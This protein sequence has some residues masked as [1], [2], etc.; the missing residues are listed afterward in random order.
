MASYYYTQKYRVLKRKEASFSSDNECDSFSLSDTTHDNIEDMFKQKRLKLECTSSNNESNDTSSLYL[1]HYDASKRDVQYV[2][3]INNDVGCNNLK[4]C[5]YSSFNEC[6]NSFLA[7]STPEPV[8]EAE[9]GKT[10]KKIPFREK[11]KNLCLDNINNITNKFVSQLLILLR[12]EGLDVPTC[13]ETLLGTNKKLF[14]YSIKSMLSSNG[15]N[16]QYR[17]FGIFTGISQQI[18]SI[19]YTDD[20][21]QIIV[22]ID[23]FDLYQKSSQKCWPI[24]IQLYHLEHQFQPFIAALYC[25]PGKPA[26]VHDF[27]H[28][29]VEEA[30]N[31]I[32]NGLQIKDKKFAFQLKAIICDTP[33]R[34][35]IK[36]C[37][38]HIGFFSCKRCETKGLSIAQKIG[39]RGTKK[40]NQGSKKRIFPQTDARRRTH[41]SFKTQRQN[42]HHLKGII[43]PLLKIPGFDVI[44]GVLLDYMH[45]LCIGVTKTLLHY[46]LQG[47]KVC[48]ISLRNRLLLKEM[49]ESVSNDVPSEFQRKKFDLDDIANWKATQF[50]FFL[51]YCGSF[52]RYVLSENAYK[53]YLLLFA[54][55]RIL[56]S[57]ECV[58]KETYVTY[59]NDLLI[60]FFI[61]LPTF[62]GKRSQVMNF[63]NL[64]H[65]TDDVNY[66]K[67]PLSFFSAFPFENFLGKIK[68]LVRTPANPLSQIC[69]RIS[70]LESRDLS[71]SNITSCNS[72]KKFEKTIT[73]MTNS[74]LERITYK[75]MTL[76]T[77]HPNNTVML[78]NGKICQIKDIYV[79]TKNPTSLF[80]D[81]Y[82]TVYTYKC[83]ETFCNFPCKWSNLG[84]RKVEALKS[85]ADCYR[86]SDVLNKCVLITIRDMKFAIAML[87]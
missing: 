75:N 8:F 77:K 48:K 56:C 76:T 59:A 43:S 45:L 69:R 4:D 52:L 40:T 13:A 53:H 26:C 70:E 46:W 10:E 73:E 23:G 36:C 32:E 19:N 57:A 72:Q 62:Y 9:I 39:K 80:T 16:G 12:S 6:N 63:H 87:H 78:Q 21:I 35:Y 83:K 71:V 81:I 27:M 68:S 55:C 65:I 31:L 82:I 29:F 44:S 30:T 24:L 38:G 85:S 54:A 17:Y 34:A 50:R 58:Q 2:S 25:G 41:K 79:K 67:A 61:L 5:K 64:I 37:K 3:E 28:D 42:K 60:R 33:A 74:N 86:L 14:D 47:P 20:A 66:M 11:L 49:L 51:L 1:E 7:A 84:I 18:S 22:N 15:K